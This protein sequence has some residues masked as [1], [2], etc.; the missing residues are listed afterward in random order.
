[1][2]KRFRRPIFIFIFASI[3]LHLFFW[4]GV[5]SIRLSPPKSPP[6]AVEITI[7]EKNP[8]DLTKDKNLKQIVEQD[9]AINDEKPEDAKYLSQFNQRVV[10]ETQASQNGKFSNAAQPGI[11]T[12][13]QTEAEKEKPQ[14]TRKR[15][16]GELPAL[17]DLKP[18]FS[19]SQNA[20]AVVEGQAGN[21]SQTDDYLKGVEFGI[22]TMLST[23]EFVYY[24]YYNRIKEQL[25]Q[26]WEPGV[27]D[28]V[29]MIYKQGR[30]IASAK[31][32]I[33]QILIVLDSKGELI[34]VELVSKSGIEALDDAAV[35]AFK[36]AAPFP[37][38]PQG[39]IETDG[40]IKIRWDFILEASGASIISDKYAELNE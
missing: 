30:S 31:D 21:P 17:A 22:Q 27:R 11:K 37:N 12:A 32:L 14:P 34:R 19:P 4:S 28:K 1:M 9:K 39:M 15:S 24:S 25:R 36:K 23:R 18:K 3:L 13:G 16:K 7:L 20:Q 6:K 40:T 8:E 33:T 35:D 2:L 29:K 5:T 26:H 10:K 38:P